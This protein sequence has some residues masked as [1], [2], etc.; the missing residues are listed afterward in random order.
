[1]IIKAN[2]DATFFDK[3]PSPARDEAFNR[4][5]E[6]LEHSE[7]LLIAV[8]TLLRRLADDLMYGLRPILF[9]HWRDAPRGLPRMIKLAQSGGLSRLKPYCDVDA[10]VRVMNNQT[11]WLRLLRDKGGIRDILVHQPHMISMSVSGSRPENSEHAIWGVHASLAILTSNGIQTRSILPVLKTCIADVCAFMASLT[12][13]VGGITS[14]GC[15]D[16]IALCGPD[17]SVV[18]FWPSIRGGTF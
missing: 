10:L 8:F 7:V 5:H 9:E 4:Q 2:A 15:G 13:L 12:Q 18:G 17:N 16:R 11:E 14:Y 6:A 3:E 1:M